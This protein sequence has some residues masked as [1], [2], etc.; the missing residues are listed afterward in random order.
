MRRIP[1]LPFALAILVALAALWALAQQTPRLTTP[2]EIARSV[3]IA[4]VE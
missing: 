2:E 1:L 4:L 3:P